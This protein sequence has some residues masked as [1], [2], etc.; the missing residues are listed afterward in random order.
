VLPQIP[1][2]DIVVRASPQA[3]SA[4]FNQLRAELERAVRELQRRYA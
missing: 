3:Y 4:S 1:P 2:V